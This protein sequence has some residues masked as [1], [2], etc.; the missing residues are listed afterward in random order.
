MPPQPRLL[1]VEDDRELRKLYTAAL[2]LAKFDVHPCPD[3]LAAL[4]YLDQHDVDAIVLDLHLPRVS[5]IEIYKEL[6]A[7][8]ASRDVPIVVCTGMDPVPDLPGATILYKPCAPEELLATVRRV[9]RSR[10]RAWLYVRGEQSVR[11]VREGGRGRPE[12]LVSYGPGRAIAVFDD[13]DPVGFDRR[14]AA[15]ERR[16]TAEGYEKI[17]LF[18][19][20]RRSGGDTGMKLRPGQPDRRRSD[21]LEK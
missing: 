14:H 19:A 20:D 11:I 16:L 12:R 5:G 17:V 9:L 10:Q 6:R 7:H 15:L 18:F 13:R 1:L 8:G 3:G 21:E 2:R 4:H